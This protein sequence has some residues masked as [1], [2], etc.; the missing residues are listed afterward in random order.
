MEKQKAKQTKA[1]EFSEEFFIDFANDCGFLVDPIKPDDTYTEKLFKKR[2]YDTSRV[3]E[4][5]QKLRRLLDQLIREKRLSDSEELQYF[6]EVCRR[7]VPFYELANGRVAQYLVPGPGVAILFH[8][9]WLRDLSFSLIN[10]LRNSPAIIRRIRKCENCKAYYLAKAPN[11][12]YCDNRCKRMSK[13]PR[14]KWNA[15]M[16]KYREEKGAKK[17]KQQKRFMNEPNEADK[18]AMMRALGMTREEVRIQI[19]KDKKL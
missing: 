10:Y 7:H 16:R 8:P 14:E 17:Q 3:P 12:R 13:W 4:A 9:F 5:R 1:P 2:L 19:E 11:Q 15:Y 6:V 18:Q